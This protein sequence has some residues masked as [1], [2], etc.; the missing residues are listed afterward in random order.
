MRDPYVF[1]ERS[2]IQGL[3]GLVIALAVGLAG[4]GGGSFTVPALVLVDSI[5]SLHYF[6]LLTFPTN[7]GTCFSLEAIPNDINTSDSLL[8]R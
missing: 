3:V 4:I 2:V 5:R 7:R 1:T 6:Q 8:S